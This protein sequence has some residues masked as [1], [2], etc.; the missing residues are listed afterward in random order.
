M[1]KSKKHVFWEA[2]IITIVIFLIGLFLGMLI[3]TGHS[4][5]LND[6]YLSSEIS[7]MDGMATLNLLEGKSI[8]CEVLRKGNI[9]F[10]D[11][12][13]EEG[14]LL[15]MYEGSGKLLDNIKSLHKKYD[16]LRT[17]LW[18]SNQEALK[19]CDNFNLVVYLYE[20]NTEEV[21]KKAT[22]N[23]WSKILLDSKRANEDVLLIPIAADQNITSLNLL[24]SEHNI[25]KFPA[26]IINNDNVLY[27][28]ENLNQIETLLN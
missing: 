28:L 20:L 3:E 27:S 5:E 10:A 25:T 9:E 14:K 7:L 24:I 23:V 17:M 4:V 19:R 6:L 22:Q 18:M 8:D 15:D 26:V 2:F 16:L 21:R 13:Y 12:V 1:L 11:K